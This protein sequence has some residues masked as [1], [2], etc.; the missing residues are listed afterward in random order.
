MDDD[1]SDAESEAGGIRPIRS[2]GAAGASEEYD[3]DDDDDMVRA[4]GRQSA[5]PWR[6]S[7]RERAR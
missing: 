4:A 2:A 5:H 7:G 6:A 3:D 1:G